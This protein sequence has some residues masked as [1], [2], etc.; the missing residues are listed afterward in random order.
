MQAICATGS[1]FHNS[2][3]LETTQMLNKRKIGKLIMVNSDSEILPST[4]KEP[5]VYITT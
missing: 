2:S 1:S 3:K 5:S 4:K